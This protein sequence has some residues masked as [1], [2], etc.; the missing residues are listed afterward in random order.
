[1]TTT[2]L[3]AREKEL[4]DMEKVAEEYVPKNIESMISDSLEA[5]GL[6][7]CYVTF[8]NR[9]AQNPMRI[10]CGIQIPICNNDNA[11]KE[12]NIVSWLQNLFEY[13]RSSIMKNDCMHTYYFHS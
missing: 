1:M 13:I 7:K 11:V 2:C 9:H 6:R 5:S 3:Y 12:M 10:G 4:L 8:E